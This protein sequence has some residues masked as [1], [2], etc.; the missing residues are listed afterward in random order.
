[1]RYP[2]TVTAQLEVHHQKHKKGE[3]VPAELGF[4]VQ[5]KLTSLAAGAA[6]AGVHGSLYT[7]NIVALKQTNTKSGYRRTV[8]R[9][10]IKLPQVAKP[11]SAIQIDVGAVTG[12]F[13]PGS[14]LIDDIDIAKAVKAGSNVPPFPGDLV[15]QPHRKGCCTLGDFFDKHTCASDCV[16][17]PGE[18]VLLIQQGQIVQVQKKH[19]GG[20]WWYGYVL[21]ESAKKGASAHGGDG[22]QQGQA[23]D[24]KAP[25][26]RRTV[27]PIQA[28]ELSEELDVVEGK[29]SDLTTGAAAAAG[30]AA[31]GAAAPGGSSAG[32]RTLDPAS[33]FHFFEDPLTGQTEWDP[34]EFPEGEGEVPPSSP[35][36][37]GDDGDTDDVSMTRGAG[38]FPASYVRNPTAQELKN[39]QN[40]L[41]GVSEGELE[42]QLAELDRKNKEVRKNR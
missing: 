7:V 14:V 42:S 32:E 20:G 23:R 9:M 31:A 38:W 4:D 13:T 3:Q 24:S 33:G 22:G 30:G 25:S 41:A 27:A 1:V 28:G 6:F 15:A 16:A 40:A 2:K 18:P 39:L 17:A 11:K 5:G 34:A 36:T 10:E 21:L 19:D 37:D 8:K 26:V 35:L 29:L 12:A